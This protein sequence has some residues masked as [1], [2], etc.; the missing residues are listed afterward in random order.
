MGIPA[1]FRWIIERYSKCLKPAVEVDENIFLLNKN[2][3]F[4]SLYIDA[5][6]LL[7]T[8]VHP[9]NAT[10]PKTFEHMV[11][12]FL[13]LLEQQVKIIRPRS[14]L[15][16]SFDGVAPRAKMNLQRARRY[17]VAKENEMKKDYIKKI[18]T[19]RKSKGASVEEEID[20]PFDFSCITPGTRFM[21]DVSVAVQDW[22]RNKQLDNSYWSNLYVVVDD[23][24]SPGEGE[25]KIMRC[26]RS[27]RQHPNYN[28]Q[29][30]IAISGRDADLIILGLGTHEPNIS[31]LRQVTYFGKMVRCPM[32]FRAGHARE[33]VYP[34]KELED[35]PEVGYA[36][37]SLKTF[38]SFLWSEFR[39]ASTRHE[40]SIDFEI[41]VNDFM[42]LTFFVGNDFLPRLA[43]TCIRNG[44]LDLLIECYITFV[45]IHGTTLTLDNGKINT[46]VLKDFLK[47][48]GI[49]E[50]E[51][52]GSLA[53][54]NRNNIYK[55]K[56]N[57]KDEKSSFYKISSSAFG[58]SSDG[59]EKSKETRDELAELF[60]LAIFNETSMPWFNGLSKFHQLRSRCLKFQRPCA[61]EIACSKP[62]A[63]GRKDIIPTAF[64]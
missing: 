4:D 50:K 37:F 1:F 10:S 53:K 63:N 42:L 59:T 48:V 5:N 51:I 6:D 14:L 34:P 3:E 11:E 17:R 35:H 64:P 12:N 20:E 44:S 24:S 15:Y 60:P 31:I 9:E 49:H 56:K 40:P 19:Y 47:L 23:A 43:G 8:A 39:E 16:I 55:K 21:R 29:N 54:L 38:R 28:P 30:A 7:H 41:M 27:A 61:G 25:H 26:I 2:G 45:T 36:L 46:P 13:F 57:K 52:V 62:L 58:G 18:D 32:C 22:I 33:C